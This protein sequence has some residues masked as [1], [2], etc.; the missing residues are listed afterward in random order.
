MNMIIS[1]TAVVATASRARSE[2]ED[3]IFAAIQVHK[4]ALE[5]MSAAVAEA[6]RLRRLA[7]KKFGPLESLEDGRRKRFVKYLDSISPDGDHDTVTN[8]AADHLAATTLELAETV[9]T[10]LQGLLSLACH[11]REVIEH[12]D[13]TFDD[14]DLQTLLLSMS[15][16]AINVMAD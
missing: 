13:T 15:T 11:A 16:A 3:P 7:E 6:R 12:K 1:T 5:Q 4:N 10:S 2:E 9:P 14:L 8:V